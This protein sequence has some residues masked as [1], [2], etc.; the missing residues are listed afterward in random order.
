MM[1]WIKLMCELMIMIEM[2]MFLEM[3][4]LYMNGIKL[5]VMI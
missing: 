2:K 1:L 5:K 3:D 4:V